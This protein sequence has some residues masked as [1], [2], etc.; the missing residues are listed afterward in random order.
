VWEEPL[1]GGVPWQRIRPSGTSP[2]GRRGAAVILDGKRDRVLVIG[3]SDGNYDYSDVWALSLTGNGAWAP[4]TTSGTPPSG[5]S[6]MAAVLDTL[7]DRV[8]VYGGMASGNPLG[9]VWEL[10]LAGTPTWA[11]LT[12]S[13]TPPA[14]RRGPA[15]VYDM[16]GDR[17]LVFGGYDGSAILDDLWELSFAGSSQWPPLAPNGGPPP[18]RYYHSMVYDPAGARAF[19][20]AGIHTAAPYLDDAWQ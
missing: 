13:G 20:Y 3:G 1:A 4:V 16:A 11:P 6:T 15:A 2:G 18:G 12:P 10:T 9:D 5:R 7:R 17:L 8:V 14:A 19:V